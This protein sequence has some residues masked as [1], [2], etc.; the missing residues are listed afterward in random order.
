[1]CI[2]DLRQMFRYVSGASLKTCTEADMIG[3]R[4]NFLF[5]LVS[6]L[7]LGACS[8]ESL[9]RRVLRRLTWRA[10]R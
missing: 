2:N 8:V 3:M 7:A 10:Q 5:V 4:S 9:A 1:M 6:L